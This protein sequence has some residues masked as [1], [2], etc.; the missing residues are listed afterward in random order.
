MLRRL[1][2]WIM[3]FAGRPSAPWVLAAVSF[4]ESSFFPLPPDPLYIAM[5]VADRKS[6]WRLAILCTVSSVV[7]GVL[8]YYIGYAL[9]EGVGGWIIETYGMEDAFVKFQNDFK[10]WGFWLIALKGLTPIPYKLVT[11]ASGVAR[12]D[13]STFITAS[14]LARG[15]RFFS[16]GALMYHFGDDIRAQLDKNLGIITITGLVALALGFVIFKYMTQI[17]TFFS[18]LF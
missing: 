18:S 7:G 11:I 8:G 12:L 5:L 2:N 9:F 13:M 15:F 17:G 3:Q 14:I 6:V 10:R 1:Y 16:L 4:A